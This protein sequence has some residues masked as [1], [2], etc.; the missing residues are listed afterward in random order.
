MVL[1]V[2][3][4][5]PEA[6]PYRVTQISSFKFPPWF[7]FAWPAGSFPL[8]PTNPSREQ[9]H[10][11]GPANCGVTSLFEGVELSDFEEDVH[12][13]GIELEQVVTRHGGE[14]GDDGR[15]G[16]VGEGDGRGLR[17][18]QHFGAVHVELL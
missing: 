4:A 11:G 2:G 9:T 6:A 15:G 16:F 7:W 12:F 17:L 1:I 14:V 18:G 13:P 8:D 5:R 10:P 3:A